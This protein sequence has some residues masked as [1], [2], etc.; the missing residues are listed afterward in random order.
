MKN[1]DIEFY[2]CKAM[3]NGGISSGRKL[4]LELGLSEASITQ[5]R[6]G[7]AFP[8]DTVMIKLATLAGIDPDVGLLDLNLWRTTGE[9][10]AGYARLL[11]KIT[12]SVIGAAVLL[13]ASA[14][15]AVIGASA[16]Q[17]LTANIAITA[18]YCI[19]RKIQKRA[20]TTYKGIQENLILTMKCHTYGY[21]A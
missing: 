3:E 1:R 21:A 2:I 4:G 6:T 18:L 9:A 13:P 19:L 8:S 7:R 16:A 10:K 14:H 15:A 20:Q 17:S 12:A 11:K 5:F